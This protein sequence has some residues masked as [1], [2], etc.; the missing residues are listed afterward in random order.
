MLSNSSQAALVSLGFGSL[1]PAVVTYVQVRSLPLI[2][3]DTTAIPWIIEGSTALT[4][5]GERHTA[6]SVLAH[7]S[8]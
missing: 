3:Q 8:A 1:P 7:L 5:T 2:I 6:N 4:Y